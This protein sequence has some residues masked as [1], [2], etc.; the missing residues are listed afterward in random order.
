MEGIQNLYKSDLV[1]YLRNQISDNNMSLANNTIMYNID[2]IILKY[3][4]RIF[5][6]SFT[7]NLNN[8]NEFQKYF[9][10]VPSNIVNLGR[11]YDAN[12][13]NSI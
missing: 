1:Y 13:S 4:A 11:Y 2:G 8:Y 3:L 10:L 7:K 12:K 9:A 6:A 5:P